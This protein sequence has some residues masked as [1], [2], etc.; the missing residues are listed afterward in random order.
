M[1]S[2]CNS[3]NVFRVCGL[4]IWWTLQVLQSVLPCNPQG[5]PGLLLEGQSQV[6][7]REAGRKGPRGATD[8]LSGHSLADHGP[9]VQEVDEMV[10]KKACRIHSECHRSMPLWLTTQLHFCASSSPSDPPFFPPGD[11]LP[12]R[13]CPPW[14]TALWKGRPARHHQYPPPFPGSLPSLGLL[15]GL[16]LLLPRA[17]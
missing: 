7:P 8:G 1:G 5:H 2:R 3:R 15:Q 14:S 4:H 12:A 6:V 11:A 13:P 17:L 10:W 16:Q 9:R